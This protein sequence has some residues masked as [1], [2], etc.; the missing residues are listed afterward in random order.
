MRI[1][2]LGAGGIGGYFGARIHQAGGDLTFLVRPARARQLRAEGLQ[3]IS[4]LGDV[5]IIPRLITSTQ[6]SASGNFEAAILSCKS[7]DLDSAMAAIAPALAPDGLVIPLLNGVAHLAPLDN[8]FGRERVL[9]GMAHLGVT[10]TSE[11]KIRH[12][13]ALHRL[14]V[15]SRTEPA[16]PLIEGLAQVLGR[17]GID[18]QLSE[19]IEREM[20]GK[21]VFLSTLAGATCVMRACIGDILETAWGEAFILGLLDECSAVAQK[22]GHLPSKE[23]LAHYR[24][25]LTMRGSTSTASMLRDIERKGPT[26]AEHI[27]GD[28]MRRAIAHGSETSFLKV[29]YSHLQAY[30]V[31]RSREASIAPLSQGQP[32]SP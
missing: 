4:P 21:F 31:R 24:A 9:G 25:Q 5:H 30:E 15:G 1:L 14:I 3:V 32:R 7:Y 26:E 20:W 22:C 11:G 16:S 12:L 18:F 19:H 6:D 17:A 2:M 8:R 27:L 10:L 23:Q 13:D 29:A 28:M